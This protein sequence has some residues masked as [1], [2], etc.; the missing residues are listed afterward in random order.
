MRDIMGMMQKAKELQDKMG[1]VQEDLQNLTVDGA[2]GAGLV[3]V[4]LSGKGDL[5]GLKI[6]PSLIADGDVEI[7]EDLIIAAH[8]DARAKSEAMA[9]EK[10]QEVTAGMPLPPGMKLPF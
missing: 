1:Q 6:D 7:I 9:A 4:T 8:A 5:R 3:A 10:M 2:S